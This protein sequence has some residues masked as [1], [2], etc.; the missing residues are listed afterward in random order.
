MPLVLG[1]GRFWR[2]SSRL[3]AMALSLSSSSCRWSS[4]SSLRLRLRLRLRPHPPPPACSAGFQLD[5]TT[6]TGGFHGIVFKGGG[7]KGMAYVGALQALENKGVTA[8][9]MT[10]FAGSS[11]GSIIAAMMAAGVSVKELER[12]LY[13]IDWQKV[14]D[15]SHFLGFE[16]INLVRFYGLYK[17]QYLEDAVIETL[18]HQQTGIARITFKQLYEQTGKFLRVTGTN[19]TDNELNV[20]DPHSAPDMPVS[21]AVHISACVPLF[22][23]SVEYKS[24]YFVDGGTL[25]NLDLTAF[26]GYIDPPERALAMDLV[27]TAPPAAS[28]ITG[29][30]QFLLALMQTLAKYAN[31]YDSKKPDNV[32]VVPI[33]TTGIN[34]LNFNISREE[35]E[36]LYDMGMKAV[37]AAFPE[38]KQKEE[39]E[40]ERKLAA[41][42]A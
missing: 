18:L 3:V 33:D 38:D 17:G 30:V 34:A 1:R 23:R 37:E 22:F 15:G 16:L 20:F 21:K 42:A 25:R 12:K 19:L 29:V 27:D 4:S 8:A 28:S 26:E 11:A 10:Y 6:P 7:V 32:D 14:M 36:K 39:E 9:S 41:P 5:P 35:Q 13:G 31:L 40:E 2:R 24:K